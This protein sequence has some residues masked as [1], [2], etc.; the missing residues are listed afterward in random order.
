MAANSNIHDDLVDKEVEQV[1]RK[2]EAEKKPMM[3]G[4]YAIPDDDDDEDEDEDDPDMD[5]MDGD[6]EDDSN[7]DGINEDEDD[8]EDIEQQIVN[9]T[10]KNGGSRAE[11]RQ[12]TSEAIL[13]IN[14]GDNDRPNTKQVKH[15]QA[16]TSQG[17]RPAANLTNNPRYQSSE[18][19]DQQQQ[20]Y[21]QAQLPQGLNQEQYQQYQEQ[22]YMLEQQQLQE[23]YAMPQQQ[24]QQRNI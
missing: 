23:Q 9:I 22:N 24:Y 8:D 21:G 16:T 14:N 17:Q 7:G 18:G 20:Q 13:V 2:N 10:S 5:Q 6:M 3:A 15:R 11:E 1:I 19:Y 12:P 4:G